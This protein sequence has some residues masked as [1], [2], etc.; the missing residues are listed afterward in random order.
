MVSGEVGFEERDERLRGTV[1]LIAAGVAGFLSRPGGTVRVIWRGNPEW[2]SYTER[3]EH[4]FAATDQLTD[5]L[6]RGLPGIDRGP[7]WRSQ[8]A[9]VDALTHVDAEHALLVEDGE[10]G[11]LTVVTFRRK[12]GE[13]VVVGGGSTFPPTP[14]V[15]P[16]VGRPGG[17]L[18][19][20]AGAGAGAFPAWSAGGPAVAGGSAFPPALI[21]EDGSTFLP[22]PGGVRGDAPPLS[23]EQASCVA[24]YALVSMAAQ[25]MLAVSHQVSPETWYGPRALESRRLIGMDG[26]TRGIKAPNWAAADVRHIADQVT[27]R[28]AGGQHPFPDVQ[29]HQVSPSAYRR[30]AT[31]LKGWLDQGGTIEVYDH[32]DKKQRDAADLAMLELSTYTEVLA[33]LPIPAQHGVRTVVVMAD[34]QPQGLVTAGRNA[35]G[36]LRVLRFAGA[37]EIGAFRATELMMMESAVRTGAGVSFSAAGAQEYAGQNEYELSA[38]DAANWASRIRYNLWQIDE[39]SAARMTELL[40]ALDTPGVVAVDPAELAAAVQRFRESGGDVLYL[41]ASDPRFVALQE[42]VSDQLAAAMDSDGRVPPDVESLWQ[43]IVPPAAEAGVSSAAADH[44]RVAFAVRDG[45]PVAAVGITQTIARF[46]LGKLGAVSGADDALIAAVVEGAHRRVQASQP[47]VMFRTVAE[48]ESARLAAFG[49]ETTGVRALDDDNYVEVRLPRAVRDAVVDADLASGWVSSTWIDVVATGLDEFRHD[50]GEVLRL[51]HSVEADR[52]L[53]EEAVREVLAKPVTAPSELPVPPVNGNRVTLLARSEPQGPR[54][55]LTFDETPAG[56]IEVVDVNTKRPDYAGQSAV[57]YCFA[58]H[59]ANSGQR[60][61]LHER[62][63]EVERLGHRG[64]WGPEEGRYLVAAIYNRLGD[65]PAQL[66]RPAPE[67]TPAAEAA[68]GTESAA[69]AE[70]ESASAAGQEQGEAPRRAGGAE[71]RRKGPMER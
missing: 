31:E 28:Q 51:D 13:L 66:L 27:Q 9:A 70:S 24:Q 3:L 47:L 52:V 15:G 61:V 10:N 36:D 22:P 35:N 11:P 12:N 37:V 40:G 65:A 5:T 2:R 63:P 19:D 49:L 34:G 64:T 18:G 53:A 45:V 20:G 68:V 8:R 54:A 4:T 69:G 59:L 33:D 67:S 55:Y 42:K 57:R 43:A 60:P 44:R 29:F 17:L 6:R 25:E 58:D 1:S 21:A 7:G 16:A 46:E 23:G 39:P 32:G 71:G 30:W 56:G 26:Q 14:P 41:S 50:N 62:I 48:V 38:G